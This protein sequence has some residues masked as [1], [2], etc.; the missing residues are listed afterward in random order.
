MSAALGEAMVQVET[1]PC[2]FEPAE[3]PDTGPF[4]DYRPSPPAV[5]QQFGAGGAE[6]VD[7]L[8]DEAW[9]QEGLGNLAVVSGDTGF[10]I[11]LNE[12]DGDVRAT[13]VGLAEGVIAAG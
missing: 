11:Q 8:G 1:G 6:A 5:V 7:G 2:T 10:Q 3:F 12:Y 13:V 4:I 9:F